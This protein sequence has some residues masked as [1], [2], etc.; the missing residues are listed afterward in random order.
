MYVGDI[1]YRNNKQFILENNKIILKK[2]NWSFAFY[3]LISSIFIILSFNLIFF[4]FSN[5]F[6]DING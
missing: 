1:D 3:H 6:N 4:N 5:F 2:I